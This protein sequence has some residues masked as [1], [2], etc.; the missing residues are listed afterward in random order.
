MKNGVSKSEIKNAVKK[1]KPTPT[2]QQL[3][4][5]P[6]IPISKLRK[7]PTKKKPIKK[8]KPQNLS[9]IHEEIEVEVSE[10]F[11]ERIVKSKK[12]SKKKKSAKN[13]SLVEKQQNMTLEEKEKN[14]VIYHRVIG[15]H[16]FTYKRLIL[17]DFLRGGMGI[18]QQRLLLQ[19]KADQLEEE[20]E[21]NKEKMEL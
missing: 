3:D 20:M 9:T 2:A 1:Q 16:D 6:D 12:V 11:T 5:N 13:E 15:D 14:L 10:E 21:V 17:G 19:N 18:Y 7:K 8:R 4:Q